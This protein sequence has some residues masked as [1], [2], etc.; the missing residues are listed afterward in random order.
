MTE[1][2]MKQEEVALPPISRDIV[3]LAR[4]P[5]EM[6]RAQQGLIV[7]M[8]RK[9]EG[10]RAELVEAEENLATAKRLKHRTLGWQRQVQ[11]ARKRVLYYEK[12]KTALESG[13]C[14]IPDFPVQVIAVRTT[15][16]GPSAKGFSGR[17]VP[18]MKCETLPEGEGDYIDPEPYTASL[19][20]EDGSM[21][22]TAIA[23]R[24]V[25][26]PFKVIKPQ[27]L[28]GLEEALKRKLFDEIGVLPAHRA[29]RDPILIGRIK[30]REGYNENTMTFLIA[31]WIDTRS[32]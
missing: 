30:R 4:D 17:R 11:V 32:L 15:K 14:I 23:L 10:L 3:V 18:D 21:V 16:G 31:W 24:E 25:D 8:D 28:K 9:L 7:W 19:K 20:R 13:Y 6:A 12:A 26:F 5:E 29:N 27:I 1:E 2:I 22:T